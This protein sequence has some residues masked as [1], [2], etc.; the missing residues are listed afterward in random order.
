MKYILASA[1]PRRK[2]LFS[3]LGYEFKVMPANCDEN[4]K[5]KTIIKK[6]EYTVVII[7]IVSII[8]SP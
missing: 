1:S 4:I 5:I 3:M 8:Y 2:E 6:F 7:F